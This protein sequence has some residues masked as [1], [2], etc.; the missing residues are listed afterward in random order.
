MVV[1]RFRGKRVRDRA[2]QNDENKVLDVMRTNDFDM[3]Q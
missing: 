3:I 1:F 2:A